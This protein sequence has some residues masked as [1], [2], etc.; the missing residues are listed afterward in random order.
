M[1]IM[2]FDLAVVIPCF[3]EQ[4]NLE[5]GVLDEVYQYLDHQNFSW[6][7]IVVEFKV[8]ICMRPHLTTAGRPCQFAAETCHKA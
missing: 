4:K 1:P 8:S 7:V 6:Q 5:S 3:N 2:T